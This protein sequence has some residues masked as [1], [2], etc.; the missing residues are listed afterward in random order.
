MCTLAAVACSSSGTWRRIETPHFVL[1]TDLS[2]REAKRAGI[3]L[4]T[5]RDALVSAAWS[6]FGFA[7]EKTEVYV[8]AN[9]LEFERYFGK[10]THGL[11][12]RHR[13]PRFFLYGSATRWELRRA[14]QRPTPSVLRHEMVH[15]LASEVLPR[16]PRGFSEGWA[17]FLEPIYYADDQKHVVVGALNYEALSWYRMIRTTKLTDALDWK[18]GVSTM[19]EREAKGLYGISWLFVHWLFHRRP[20]ELHRFVEE[21]RRGAPPEQA[22]QAA[23]PNFDP[24]AIDREL[25]QYQRYTRFTRFDQN[26]RPLVETPVSEATLA[27]RRLDPRE[28]EVVKEL[29]AAVG[30]AHTGRSHRRDPSPDV[31]RPSDKPS[32]PSID[33][34]AL[35][36]LSQY[37]CGPEEGVDVPSV[38]GSA[39]GKAHTRPTHGSESSES[40]DAPADTPAREPTAVAPRAARPFDYEALPKLPQYPCGPGGSVDAALPESSATEPAASRPGGPKRSTG[41]GPRRGSQTTSQWPVPT[42]R[43]APEIVQ[44]IIRA[45][46]APLRACYEE[47]RK[48][49]ENLGGKV[50]VRFDIEADGTVSRYQPIC[51]SL[52][53]PKVVSCIAQNFTKLQFPKPTGG[54]V[55]VVYPVTFAPGD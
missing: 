9:G 6:T 30:E 29:L 21:L 11:F 39:M 25:F 35:P 26:L 46:Y 48:S 15:Q 42:G 36:M 49:T 19:A 2:Q 18:E 53:D 4:E 12:A 20:A 41:A 47:G 24:A 27:E 54:I 51:T 37:P 22:L 38:G 14:A 3:A 31:A 43:L 45:A 40:P 16:N 13:P 50:T 52:P 10:S 23:L 28:V 8:L 5:T 32:A 44:K 17:E 7:A 34:A 1:R 33:Y 55:R